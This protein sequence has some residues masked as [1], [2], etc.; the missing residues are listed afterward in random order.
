MPRIPAF[1][2]HAQPDQVDC[3][4]VAM[5]TDS[6]ISAENRVRYLRARALSVGGG[7]P[8]IF[9]LSGGFNHA[10]LSYR[11]E[12]QGGATQE[13]SR[14]VGNIRF[15]FGRY[16]TVG[17]LAAV[18]FNYEMNAKPPDQVH[19][20]QN[21]PV[22][23]MTTTPPT[24]QCDDVYLRG[25][26]VTQTIN[27]RAEWRQYLSRNLAWNPS[28]TFPWQAREGEGSG[29]GWGALQMR[30]LDID[31]PFYARFG[32][33]LGAKTS[34]HFGVRP[35]MRIWT[36]TRSGSPVELNLSVFLGGSFS[37]FPL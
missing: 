34:L 26:T 7:G 14:F 20:C 1:E 15:G 9:F 27:L 22:N 12:A 24:L 25:Y 37:L 23:G 19:L 10:S 6:R 17:G 35:Q 31:T 32:E 21:H 36:E 30:Y 13:D 2:I 5:R 8:N 28:V 16:L 11:N 3:G 4:D 29:G 18:S 33:D